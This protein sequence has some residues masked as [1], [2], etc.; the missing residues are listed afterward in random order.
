MNFGRSDISPVSR[1]KN[2]K[3]V[4]RNE[5]F[6]QLNRFEVSSGVKLTRVLKVV[7]IYANS[8]CHETDLA[9]ILFYRAANGGA[10]RADLVPDKPAFCQ[11]S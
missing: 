10:V 7:V 9:N 6:L 5:V 1:G 11:V 2:I 4:G 3:W 8:I